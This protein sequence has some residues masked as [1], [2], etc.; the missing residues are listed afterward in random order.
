MGKNGGFSPSSA[1]NSMVLPSKSGTGQFDV[2]ILQEETDLCNKEIVMD[3]P[4][5]KPMETRAVKEKKHQLEHW[6]FCRIN[7]CPAHYNMPTFGRHMS[8]D[9]YYQ[10]S[11]DS[12]KQGPQ[13]DHK[14]P[15]GKKSQNVQANNRTSRGVW[16]NSSTERGQPDSQSWEWGSG[17]MPKEG[18]TP[19]QRP[20]VDAKSRYMPA[21]P[22]GPSKESQSKKSEDMD[23]TMESRDATSLPKQRV[24]P[25]RLR[26]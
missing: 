16:V 26:T 6:S 23:Q 1:V 20:H 7:N 14:R 11:D 13:H 3:Q 19:S 17:P 9:E 22:K 2:L 5:V 10:V 25:G 24:C 21:A 18:Q 4:V 15:E 8:A 12:K